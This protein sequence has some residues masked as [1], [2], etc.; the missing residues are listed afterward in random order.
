MMEH[1]PVLLEQCVEGLRIK[2]GGIYIDGTLGRGGHA[3]EIAKKIKHGRLI[4]F[5]RDAD[6][7]MKA[8]EV[9]WEYADKITFIKDNFTTLTDS[10]C[11][12]DISAVDG[13][14][15]DLGV[16][17]PQLDEAQRGFSYMKDAPLDMRMDKDQKLTAF[18]VVNTWSKEELRRIF[19]E[20]GEEKYANLIAQ[21]IVRSREK[22][23]INTTFDLNEIIISAI[24][25]AARRE[26][27]HPSK[28]CFQALRIAVNDE[29]D[30]LREMIA[31][32]PDA[33]KPGGRICVISFHSLE[34]RIVKNEF[35]SRAK[36]CVCPKSFPVCV[37]GIKPTLKIITRK[38]LVADNEELVN[39]PRARS[40]KLRIAEKI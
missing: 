38:P 19:F 15:F 35:A 13:M 23:I 21:N 4:C 8:R 14:L 25:S 37:C 39:N 17:S 9:L 31:S 7:I 32:A 22:E 40:A 28:R 11:R 16:S 20:Y 34:D 30:A 29:L 18:E 5:D 6:A 24:P 27:Q 36:G 10:V 1:T 12:L 2:P 26:A 3:I 33:L